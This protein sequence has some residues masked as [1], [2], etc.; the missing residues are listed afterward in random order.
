MTQLD[1]E[2]FRQAVYEVVRHIPYGRATSYGAVARAIGYS[3][4]SRLVGKMMG[5]CPPDNDI[6]AHRVVNSQ[7][8]LS[9][10]E[11]FGN[12]DQMQRLLEAEG[13]KVVNNRIRNWKK[14][15]WN[16]IEELQDDSLL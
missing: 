3:N 16:P 12:A 1:K 14:I 11:A 15:F 13:I 4:M 10:R 7:G 5:S 2:D 6:P 9:G 8:I